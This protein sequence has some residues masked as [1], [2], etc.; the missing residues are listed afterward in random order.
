M[1]GATIAIIT[2]PPPAK[3]GAPMKDTISAGKDRLI[4][5]NATLY[6]NAAMVKGAAKTKARE[7]AEA[8]WRTP[9]SAISD[10]FGSVPAGKAMYD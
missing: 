7:K 4:T 1:T 2:R 10:A 6:K 3:A 9:Q 5:P 8:M